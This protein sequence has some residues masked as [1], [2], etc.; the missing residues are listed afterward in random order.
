MMLFPFWDAS[1]LLNILDIDGRLD[2][3]IAPETIDQY[4]RLEDGEK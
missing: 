4:L 2:G 3:A 1:V